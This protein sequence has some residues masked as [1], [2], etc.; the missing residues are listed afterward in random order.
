MS[1]HCGCRWGRPAAARRSPFTVTLG[2]DGQLALQLRQLEPGSPVRL[3]G[4]RAGRAG[5]RG[6]LTLR[7]AAGRHS[8]AL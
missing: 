7:M 2:T 6:R 8:V 5:P 1:R 4:K 3:D